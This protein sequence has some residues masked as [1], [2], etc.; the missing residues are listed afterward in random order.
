MT[1]TIDDTFEVTFKAKEK[2][3]IVPLKRKLTEYYTSQGI[4]A[5]VGMTRNSLTI[6]GVRLEVVERMVR[7]YVTGCSYIRKYSIKRV[8]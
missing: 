2:G 7:E 8:S 4:Q 6:H 1:T 5:T 3:A